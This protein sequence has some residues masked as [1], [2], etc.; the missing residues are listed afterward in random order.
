[1]GTSAARRGPTSRR[2]RL[3]KGAAT[4]YLSPEGGRPVTAREVVARYAAALEETTGPEGLDLLGSFRLTRKTGQNLGDFLTVA[5]A[6]GWDAALARWGLE[7]LLGQ[8]SDLQAQALSASLTG[9][10]GSLE[11]AATRTAL[12]QTIMNWMVRKEPPP[13]PSPEAPGT[14]PAAMVCRFLADALYVRLVHDL[15][16]PL[17]AAGHS[18]AHLRQGLEGLKRWVEQAL[19]RA[20]IPVSP[21]QEQW[22]GLAG[23][24][25][26]TQV[27]DALFR[28]LKE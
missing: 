22:P 20:I 19:G 8:A 10:S 12:V 25:W 24:T 27:M 18:Y 4:R 5:A 14:S 15:G 26:V 7:D 23:W 11:E 1:M 17:E 16:E 28:Q 2:W 9:A 13:L 21:N 3:A 6:Q